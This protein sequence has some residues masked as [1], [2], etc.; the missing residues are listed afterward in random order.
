MINPF[1]R[2]ES[3]VS[4]AEADRQFK[5]EIE[6]GMLGR[7]NAPPVPID[8][9]GKLRS[10]CQESVEDLQTIENWQAWLDDPRFQ[11]IQLRPDR[12]LLVV[13]KYRADRLIAD[14]LRLVDIVPAKERLPFPETP[15]PPLSIPDAQ[16]ALR[17]VIDWCNSVATDGAPSSESDVPAE[18]R[19][20]GLP[21]G[22]PLT[23]KKLADLLDVNESLFT[24]NDVF[25]TRIKSGRGFV[26]QW[27]AA[28]K[29]AKQ[30]GIPL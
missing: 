3:K 19:E 5:M 2:P 9:V 16:F 24:R 13:G 18:Y 6:E 10:L 29:Y 25:G 4:M 8:S 28:Q 30:K 17:R 20:G 7:L 1:C 21:D 27:S 23:A 12:E 15:R 11:K 14:I 26:Y 22:E